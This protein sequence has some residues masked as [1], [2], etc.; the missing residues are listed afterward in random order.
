MDLREILDFDP[1]S[2][3]ESLTD[4]SY[5][6]DETTEMIGFYL[7]L[8]HNQKKNEILKAAK[9]S[10]LNN[11]LIDYL[12]IIYDIGFELAG[13][14]KFSNRDGTVEETQYLFAHRELGIIL[15]FDT[16]GANH[17]NSGSFFYCWKPNDP[18]D[19]YLVTSSG[20]FESESLKNWRNDPNF[21]EDFPSDIYWSGNHDCREAIRY[22]INQL[23]ENGT[24]LPKWPVASQGKRMSGLY[25]MNYMDWEDEGIKRRG[26]S[27]GEFLRGIFMQKYNLLPQWTKDIIGEPFDG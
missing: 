7:H 15:N 23:R 26:P 24:F 20:C 4:K 1:L 2:A 25:L 12:A 22:N 10:T 9:D 17:V 19:A 5:K 27:H 18:K 6:T 3:A 21:T 8:A 13:E 16:Y 14:W 11:N